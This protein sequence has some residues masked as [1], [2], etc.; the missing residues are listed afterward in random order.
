MDGN[1]KKRKRFWEPS[2]REARRSPLTSNRVH[3]LFQGRP[4]THEIARPEPPLDI[5]PETFPDGIRELHSCSDA[6]LDICFIHGL[7]G[8]RETTWTAAGQ[9]EPW[10]GMLLPQKLANVRVLTYGYDAS[11]VNGSLNR[12]IDHAENLLID[13]SADR[14]GVGAESRPLI[15]VAHSLGGLVCKKAL[16]LSRNKP[17]KH[18]QS[19]FHHTK[20]F[21]F[22][23]TPHRGSWMAEWASVPARLLG[24]TMSTNKSLLDV[25]KPDDQLL[26]SL[27]INFWNMIRQLRDEGRTIE[28][29]CAYEE[30]PLTGFSGLRTLVV[31]KK[32]ATQEGYSSFSIHA[33]HWE[34]ARFSSMEDA[35]FKRLLGDLRRWT[36]HVEKAN[37]GEEGA[38]QY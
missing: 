29:T 35:G 37:A 6:I 19:V 10:P 30:L 17:E 7:R 8:N 26:E 38:P 22:M 24:L 32:S 9:F 27:Q 3:S 14:E 11:V 5:Q 15:F 36:K 33:N 13:L 12:L 16:L 1:S 2:P 34:M 20:G 31:S 21:I 4:E 18:L 23:G 25:L 28:I